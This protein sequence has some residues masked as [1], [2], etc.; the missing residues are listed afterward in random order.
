MHTDAERH[1]DTCTH[2]RDSN[3]AIINAFYIKYC[4]IL[5]EVVEEAK[6]QPYSR[7]KLNLIIKYKHII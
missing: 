2:I 1:T 6:K 3:D 5:D 7:L 4:K